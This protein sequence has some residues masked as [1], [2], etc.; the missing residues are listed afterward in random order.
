MAE[1]PLCA[2]Y[3]KAYMYILSIDLFE[4]SRNIPVKEGWL[5]YNHFWVFKGELEVLIFNQT[6]P[7]Q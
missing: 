6:N 7:L 5:P 2:L 1:K 3:T 4:Y